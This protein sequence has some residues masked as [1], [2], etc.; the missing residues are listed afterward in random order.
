MEA[1]CYLE[2]MPWLVSERKAH[3][4]RVVET[5]RGLCMLYGGDI[6][7]TELI[8]VLHDCA[9]GIE[10]DL[11]THYEHFVKDF[12]FYPPTLH[13]PLGAFWAR[14]YFGIE[15][16]TVL[17]GIHYHCTGRSNMPL[18]EKIVFLADAIEPGRSYQGVEELRET[19]KTSL[20]LAVQRY[21][22]HTIKYLNGKEINPLTL[23]ALRF[24]SEGERMTSLK[25]ANKICE[26]MQDKKADRIMY[27]D[28]N[29][30]TVIADYFVVASALSSVQVKTICDYV[31]E[32]LGV[33]GIRPVRIDGYSEGRWIVLD[34][35]SVIVHIFK[36]EDREFYHLERLWENGSNTVLFAQD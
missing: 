30:L 15:D 28:L 6:K 4:A 13:A 24:Y 31:Q 26:L 36:E 20:D 5:A 35:Q 33:E 8:A 7:K 25:F 23:Q 34:F 3:I 22:E 27:I 19:A 29:E 2:M 17:D 1:A 21:L 14:D 16:Q 18:E 32:K 12:I 9:K 11:L 10:K